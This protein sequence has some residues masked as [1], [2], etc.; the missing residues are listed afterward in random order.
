LIS[1]ITVRVCGFEIL[2]SE[3][4]LMLALID[5]AKVKPINKSIITKAIFFLNILFPQ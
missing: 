1:S 2:F 5:G 4:L 3:L